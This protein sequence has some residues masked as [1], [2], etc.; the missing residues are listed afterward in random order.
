[1]EQSQSDKVSSFNNWQHRDSQEKSK[2][3]TDLG[4][5]ADGADAFESPGSN[6]LVVF[7]VNW[8]RDVR[9]ENCFLVPLSFVVDKFKFV[10]NFIAFR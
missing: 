3:A 6:E 4:Q 1:M 10:V 8:S 2:Q 7:E 5:K 9:V